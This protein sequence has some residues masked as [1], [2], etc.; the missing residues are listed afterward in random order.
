MASSRSPPSQW[1]SLSAALSCSD[2]R[3]MQRTL[4]LQGGTCCPRISF[5]LSHYRAVARAAPNLWPRSLGGAWGGA[6]WVIP[7]MR[8]GRAISQTGQVTAFAQLSELRKKTITASEA[9]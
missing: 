9:V 6:G 1:R 8:T 7:S 3:P 5:K 2:R 4:L